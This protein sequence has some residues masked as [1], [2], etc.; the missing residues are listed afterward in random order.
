M[1]AAKLAAVRSLLDQTRSLERRVRDAAEE[2]LQDLGIS[3]GS[4]LLLR[5]LSDEGPTTVPSIARARGVSRQHIQTVVDG[6][7]LRDLVERIENPAHKRSKLIRLSPLGE[8][9]LAEVDRREESVWLGLNLN[10]RRRELDAATDT[11]GQLRAR[12]E[13]KAW[14]KAVRGARS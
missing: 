11:I 5:F 14:R 13:S 9:L 6:L 1:K 4:R 2:Y 7:R 12:L 8:L 10:V 3:A